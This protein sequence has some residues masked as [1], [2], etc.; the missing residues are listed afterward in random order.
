MDGLTSPSVGNWATDIFK[1]V[2]D[3]LQSSS[4]RYYLYLNSVDNLKD[5][6]YSSD[7]VFSRCYS[8]N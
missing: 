7:N 6:M 3:N 8:N 5:I 2:Y 4:V 1:Y